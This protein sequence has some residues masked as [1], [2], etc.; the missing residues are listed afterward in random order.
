VAP[1]ERADVLTVYK[2]VTTFLSAQ[3]NLLTLQESNP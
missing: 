3:M 2:H 1:F